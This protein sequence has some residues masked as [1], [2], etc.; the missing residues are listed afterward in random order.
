MT[1]GD[2]M[3][4]K[5]ASKQAAR[6][7]QESVG[8]NYQARLRQVGG[9]SGGTEVAA[10]WS[11]VLAKDEEGARNDETYGEAYKRYLRC[12]FCD[13]DLERPVREAVAKDRAT[14]A[15][16]AHWRPREQDNNTIFAA[17]LYCHGVGQCLEAAEAIGFLGDMHAEEFTGSNAIEWL[18]SRAL[19]H[20]KWDSTALRRVILVC[21][22]LEG[23]PVRAK[24]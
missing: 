2:D 14:A 9:G 22:A 21:A 8:G 13:R 12:V 24:N 5:N 15:M 23:L 20:R 6:A 3:T 11:R 10:W 7:L 17:G 18:G 19:D 16:L 4:K 1:N